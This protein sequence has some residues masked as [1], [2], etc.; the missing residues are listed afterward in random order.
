MDP[1]EIISKNSPNKIKRNINNQLDEIL[2]VDS[3]ENYDKFSFND[4]I[5]TETMI[6]NSI[7]NY[8]NIES[9]IDDD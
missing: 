4:F 2:E 3:D 7:K 5:P 8:N 6:R 1:G 9:I